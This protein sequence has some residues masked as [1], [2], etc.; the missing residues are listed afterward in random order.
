MRPSEKFHEAIANLARPTTLSDVRAFFG[1]VEEIAYTFHSSKIMAPFRELLKPKNAEKGKITWTEELDR[2]FRKAKEAM[3]AAIDGG[4]KI[5]NPS[6]PT[7]VETDW[8]TSGIGPTLTQ[9]HC[10]C[11]E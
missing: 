11:K 9:K 1:L 2:A 7:A 6:L 5:F 8:S 4:V 3:M 10:D